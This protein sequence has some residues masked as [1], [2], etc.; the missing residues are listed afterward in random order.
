MAAFANEAILSWWQEQAKRCLTEKN[1]ILYW[2]EKR[3][4]DEAQGRA[5]IF[6]VTLGRGEFNAIMVEDGPWPK[7]IYVNKVAIDGDG[8][9]IL[10]SR[11][12]GTW[13]E[14][15]IEPKPP[16]LQMAPGHFATAW[17]ERFIKRG[18]QGFDYGVFEG[19]PA[20]FW[21]TVVKPL[22]DKYN[23]TSTSISI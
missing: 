17:V 13:E 11:H 5:D 6:I 1:K 12:Y 18:P 2:V 23:A 16:A 4:A 15:V 19:Q 20:E 21:E 3:S 14:S 22:A 9:A 8:N 7:E 10:A